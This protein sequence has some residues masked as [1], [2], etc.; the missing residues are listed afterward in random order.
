[1]IAEGEVRDAAEAESRHRASH[2]SALFR[3]RS[4]ALRRYAARYVGWTAAEDLVQDVFLRA[5]RSDLRAEAI[6]IGLLR[7]AV[8]NAALDTVRRRQRWRKAVPHLV[9]AE[10][11]NDSAADA[12]RDIEEQLDAAKWNAWLEQAISLLPER[13]GVVFS[14]HRTQR[15]SYAAIALALGISVRTVE[16]HMRRA[17]HALRQTWDGEMRERR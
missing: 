14:M 16:T 6:T 1:M 5:W 10:A 7:R 11:A 2:L 3:L 15:Q 17:T 12:T 8:R 4:R 9:L 13:Q